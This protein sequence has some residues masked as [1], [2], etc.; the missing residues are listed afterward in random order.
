MALKPEASNYYSACSCKVWLWNKDLDLLSIIQSAKAKC[1][2]RVGLGTLKELYNIYRLYLLLA[3]RECIFLYNFKAKITVFGSM[4]LTIWFKVSKKNL[5]SHNF[6]FK[7]SKISYFWFKVSQ[8]N[9]FLVQGIKNLLFLVQ[10]I[11]K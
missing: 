3:L 7:V 8:I 2:S 10:G 1:A 11:E 5:N 6:W 4:Y 9:I